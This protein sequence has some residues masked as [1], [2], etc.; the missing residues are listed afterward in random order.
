MLEIKASG[1]YLRQVAVTYRR[2]TSVVRNF[3]FLAPFSVFIII[4]LINIILSTNCSYVI[5]PY[6]TNM[7]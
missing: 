3:K 7:N 5:L 6:N 1:H 2:G 4:E